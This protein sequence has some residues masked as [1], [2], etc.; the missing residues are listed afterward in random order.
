MSSRIA[1]SP[2]AVRCPGLR[3][4]FFGPFANSKRRRAEKLRRGNPLAFQE[5][6]SRILLSV[7]PIDLELETRPD[8]P[9]LVAEVEH[10]VL[11]LPGIAGT[12]AYDDPTTT[13]DEADQWYSQRG[14]EP[15]KLQVDPLAK[16]Y[17]D[18]IKTLRNVGY[19]L[20]EDLIVANY[21]WRMDVGPKDG[22]FDGHLDGLT[23]DSITDGTYEFGVDYLG[24]W[25]AYA[26]DQW[27]AHHG[28]DRPDSVDIISHS[29]GGLVARAYIQSDAYGGHVSAGYD[30]PTVNDLFMVGV[31][32]QGAS[33]AWNMLHDDWDVET[34]F[35]VVLSKIVD[36]AYERLRGPNG[37]ISGPD[38]DIVWDGNGDGVADYDDAN[39]DDNRVVH[40]HQEFINA[41]VPTARSLLATYDFLD[42]LDDVPDVGFTNV[43]DSA[44]DRNAVVLDLNDGLG[45]DYQLSELHGPS[46]SFT[47]DTS[48]AQAQLDELLNNRP[49]D[50]AELPAWQRQ[51]DQLQAEI[52][53]AHER[54]PNAFIDALA[55]DAIVIYTAQARD[56]DGNIKKTPTFTAERLGSVGGPTGVME[57]E[58]L[59]FDEFLSNHPQATDRWYQEISVMDGGDGT[60]P[61]IS[62]SGQFSGDSRG[63]LIVRPVTPE[64]IADGDVLDHTGLMGFREVQRD[65]VEKLIGISPSNTYISRDLKNSSVESFVAVLDFGI[66]DAEDLLELLDEVDITLLVPQLRPV[67]DAF[68]ALS[69]AL[70]GLFNA[71]IPL[72]GSPLR[73]LMGMI[74]PAPTELLNVFN[75]AEN[76][77]PS[78]GQLVRALPHVDDQIDNLLAFVVTF[79][80]RNPWLYDI[81]EN[82]VPE[83][84]QL[85]MPFHLTGDVG[86]ADLP[87]FARKLDIGLPVLGMDIDGE[88]NITLT[89]TLDFD[90][91]LDFDAFAAGETLGT[92]YIDTT[93]PDI[94]GTEVPELQ[95]DLSVTMPGF[96]V[97]F[98]GQF[99]LLEV[100][101]ED[102]QDADDA[103]D[104]NQTGFTGLFGRF[105]VDLHQADGKLTADDLL[106]LDP[107][108]L[109]DARLT[110][111]VDVNLLLTVDFAD[112]DFMPSFS[113]EFD[114]DWDFDSAALTGDPTALL[115]MSPT[116]GFN[117]IELHLGTFFSRF[118]RPII[119]KLQYTFGFLEPLTDV[120]DWRI[121]VLSDFEPLE[122][123]FTNGSEVQLR[124]LLAKLGMGNLVAFIDAV[125]GLHVATDAENIHIDFGSFSIAAGA[126]L[127]R[128]NDLQSVGIS[129]HLSDPES[130]LNALTGQ[131]RSFLNAIDNIPGG[132]N[133]PVLTDPM[134]LVNLLLGRPAVLFEWAYHL[135]GDVDIDKRVEL[136]DIPGLPNPHVDFDGGLNFHLNLD[137]GYDTTGL[138][139]GDLAQGFFIRDKHD[140]EDKAELSI[141]G[142]VDADVGLGFGAGLRVDLDASGSISASIRFDLHDPNDD[143]VVRG[144][145]IRSMGAD[146][147]IE[148]EGRLRAGFSASLWVGIKIDPPGPGSYTKKL[149]SGSV[150]FSTKTLAF[151]VHCDE[152]VPDPELATLLSNGVLRLNV[153]GDAVYRGGDYTD[154]DIDEDYIVTHIGGTEGDESLRVQAF[155]FTQDFHH[156]ATVVATDAGAGDDSLDLGSVWSNV[157]VAGG[158][159]DDV[160]I[161]GFGRDTLRGGAGNDQIEGGDDDDT[162][163]GDEPGQAGND[164]LSGGEGDDTIT[165]GSGRDTIY[166]DAGDDIL[167]GGLADAGAGEDIDDLI[168][169]GLGN[170]QLY[171]D[172]GQ[173]TLEGE[174]GNDVV[175][176][177][178]DDDIISWQLGDGVDTIDGGEG[179]FDQLTIT[180]SNSGDTFSVS[181]DGPY[182]VVNINS[183][184]VRALGIEYANLELGQ[185][186]DTDGNP[187]P[188]KGKDTVALAGTSAAD[189]FT[190]SAI[191][192]VVHVDGLST[193]VSILGSSFS[194]DTLTVDADGGND[195]INAGPSP[196]DA[197]G[198]TDAL[199][200]LRL[201]G[202]SGN[203][204]II[205]SALADYIDSGT[206]DDRVTGAP[207][208][209]TFVD[210][211]GHD[212]IEETRDADFT[213]SD[214]SL[215]IGSEFE[216]LNGQFEEAVLTGGPSANSFT[217]Q[218][219]TGH[220][221]LDGKD[222]GDSYV[223]HF[224]GSG[225]GE[226]TIADTGTSGSDTVTVNGTD[227][228]DAFTLTANTVEMGH[229]TEKVHYFGVESLTVN[230]KGGADVFQVND[231][232][233]ATTLNGGNGNDRFT[234]GSAVGADGRPT[235]PAVPGVS[236]AAVINGEAGD[237]DFQVNRNVAPLTLN[238]GPGNDTFTIN[239]ALN[240]GA[241]HLV[242]GLVSIDGG[243]DHD[244]LVVNGTPQDDV[245]NITAS[246]ISGTGLNVTYVNIEE[247]ALNGRGGQDTFNIRGTNAGLPTTVN[248]GAD[249]DV[250]NIGSNAPGSG[251]TVDAVAGYLDVIAGEGHDTMN[252]DDAGSTTDE[253]G[254]L[255]SNHLAGLGLGALGVDY[256]ELE[257]VNIFLGGG[258]DLFT[259]L[260]TH[261]GLTSVWTGRGDDKVVVETLGGQT[262]LDG[263]E[264]EDTVVAPD[265][266]NIWHV[267]VDNGGNVTG[268]YPFSFASFENLIGGT[269][270]DRF[271]FSDGKGVGGRIDGD[272]GAD[273]GID[274]LDYTAYTTGVRVNLTSGTASNAPGGVADIEHLIGGSGDDSLTGDGHDNIIIGRGGNDAIN[275]MGGA[276]LLLGDLGRID[277]GTHAVH[278]DLGGDGDDSIS[279]GSGN[280]RM[281]G[282]DGGD[283]MDGGDGDDDMIGGHNVVGGVDG[284]DVMHGGAGVDVMLGDNGQIS[285]SRE[286]TLFDDIDRVAGDDIM[287]GGDGADLMWGQRGDDHMAGGEGADQM[288]GGLGSDN[289]AGE[290]GD[291]VMLGDVGVIDDVLL[292][293]VAE[294]TGDISLQVGGSGLS[295]AQR[296]EI[297]NQLLGADLV[298]LAGGTSDS[299]LR[300]VRLTEGGNDLMS[301]GAGDDSMYGQRGD[302][303]M[304]GDSGTDFIAGGR[305]DDRLDGGDGD[306]ELVGDDASIDAPGAAIHNVTNGLLLLPAH[307]AGEAIVPMLQ[308]MPGRESDAPT[309]LLPYIFGTGTNYVPYVSLVPELAHHAH[310]LAGND[311]L[312]GG[313][314]NDTMIGDD[315]TV[316]SRAVRFDGPTMDAA[317]RLTRLLL[318]LTD[319]YS[320]LVHDLGAL[321]HDSALPQA[322]LPVIDAQLVFGNDSLQGDAGNDVLIGDN[323]NFVTPRI[324]VPV[325]QADELECFI[326]G[327]LDA[328]DEAAHAVND[329]IV[330]EHNL[331]DAVVGG[332]VV[333]HVDVIRA[334][335]DTL[336]GGAGDDLMIGDQWVMKSILLTLAAGG[337]GRDSR[338]GDWRDSD[339]NDAEPWHRLHQPFDHLDVLQIG[340]D[341]M[342]GGAGA[343]LMWGDGL[344]ATRT[345]LRQTADVSTLEADAAARAS[346][347]ALNALADV[348]DETAYWFDGHQHRFDQDDWH[349]QQ[350]HPDDR[351]SADLIEGADDS[352]MLFGQAGEDRL[353]GGTGADWLVGGADKDLVDGGAGTDQEWSGDTNSSQVR[354]QVRAR[355]INWGGAF[356]RFGLSASPFRPIVTESKTGQPQVSAFDYLTIQSSSTV[357]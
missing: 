10:P 67:F 179:L 74:V 142:H 331:R 180:G 325:G 52:A 54:E 309:Q 138:T 246:G 171:G 251:G 189:Q 13:E 311:Q 233:A 149:F 290:G 255:T 193:H 187:L 353:Y 69:G 222:L 319:D 20:D 99:G 278:F 324:E 11:I 232:G 274:I 318:D 111:Q 132:F 212:T 107:T 31:P 15:E 357:P 304:A 194:L 12:F 23:A 201:I 57:N 228:A 283:V 19:T 214:A 70:Q 333:H 131:A 356:D 314:G 77:T 298:L 315:L 332:Q 262:Q 55:G 50:P 266:D 110:A 288:I 239:L 323:A 27:A 338:V 267:T 190:L 8:V 88:M 322:P 17:H 245:F 235:D 98:G 128:L 350:H 35:R 123:I 16:F 139:T 308:L 176:G 295:D 115:G 344:A 321:V 86:T 76:P 236:F 220:A 124:D 75:P 47:P 191:E 40:N 84:G 148:A 178:G 181:Q 270:D 259:L 240:A 26:S 127:R 33:K 182:V 117:N 230:A 234:I 63:N 39:G 116:L 287:D 242:N 300:L 329:L 143:G 161:G 140:D 30:L 286:V 158:D 334:G 103:H 121:P 282:Q 211:S 42:P 293:D 244:S 317:E 155:G 78:L 347:S 261:H 198:V 164:T 320:D 34:G 159:G 326:V 28:G 207:G 213:L 89:F 264:D 305:G 313:A 302:D 185:D 252:V 215:T 203:D 5:M 21:D 61:T 168:F 301:G 156:V 205:G 112:S 275:G 173:D 327:T 32:N 130:Q 14:I 291:D 276:D 7:S 237:D 165:G 285:A 160:L 97:N 221:W 271:V 113:T 335:N 152:D 48:A 125:T 133:F 257:F 345:E 218:N 297:L 351:L 163:Y 289:M 199:I 256:A 6:E 241:V 60:V 92:V 223:I 210:A 192:G 122:D 68:S 79:F 46:H 330:L 105:T 227:D 56:A 3:E 104:L 341:V 202:G 208:R 80:D 151:D 134:Q 37:F 95:V 73:E 248:G 100:S 277:D 49:S 196:D 243:P 186:E 29:T 346:R 172:A 9:A 340:N 59:P 281:F 44:S 184:D 62:S 41:F 348:M 343:D 64:E 206:G 272:D 38:Y 146:C 284:D 101:V 157:T 22:S 106:T 292:L 94:H 258:D 225:N 93:N 219:W 53:G 166:G 136:F 72:V 85:V 91:V 265:V 183:N 144:D 150:H 82:K 204:R 120:L 337:W 268:A 177:G 135:N 90:V 162:I 216:M 247:L 1:A 249:N 71:Q 224:I 36:E 269:H 280:D 306:D 339:W 296:A 126:D 170:D 200:A 18:I 145:E 279:G 310:M 102:F 114:L 188:D 65:I 147:L 299:R 307:G 167:R 316:H 342:N 217:V 195:T 96:G 45:L 153:G 119:E 87:A 254:T 328:A 349:W 83:I 355:V 352:D 260:S 197:N 108:S 109:F 253:T 303:T 174:K 169:G 137:F 25:L 154:G 354:D 250:F 141:G 4:I 226:T 58:L 336:L 175:N 129:N 118:A 2:A 263:Q 231:N 66:L 312:A 209:D 229:A 81:F 238:G 24:H 294:V 43:N 51:I 273:S